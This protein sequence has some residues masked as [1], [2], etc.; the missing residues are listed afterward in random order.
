[1]YS[2]IYFERTNIEH[3]F[4]QR[5]DSAQGKGVGEDAN[6]EY[7]IMFKHRKYISYKPCFC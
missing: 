1:M 5:F 6:P 3:I 2:G 7:N 4:Y